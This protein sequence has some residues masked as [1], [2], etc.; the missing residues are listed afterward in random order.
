M[1]LNFNL[2]FYQGFFVYIIFNLYICSMKIK[3]IIQSAIDNLSTEEVVE[4][5]K[6]ED[7]EDLIEFHHSIGQNIRNDL[8][9]WHD[10][11]IKNEF[12]KQLGIDHPDDIS[13]YIMEEIWEDLNRK[14]D[15]SE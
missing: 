4:I 2:D 7:K 9:L 15:Y 13:M 10:D 6:C 14:W 12:N 8:N 11:L 3:N 5:F 1:T